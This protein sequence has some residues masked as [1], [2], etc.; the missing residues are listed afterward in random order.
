MRTPDARL[1]D[2]GR[3]VRRARRDRDMS[4]EALAQAAGLA[5]KHVSEIERA[6]RDVRLTTLLQ[7]ADGLEL[8]PSELLALY[9]EQR[10]R[11]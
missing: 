10:R 7:I 6:N 3:V 8:L 4:Q 1:V 9:D 11:A 5:A 2:F